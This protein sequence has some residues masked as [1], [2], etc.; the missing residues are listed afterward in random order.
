MYTVDEGCIVPKGWACK[1]VNIFKLAT[2]SLRLPFAMCVNTW[3]LASNLIVLLTGC[4]LHCTENDE[5]CSL[6]HYFWNR[7]CKA[8]P[9]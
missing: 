3:Y 6:G 4:H 5:D 2:M 1:V 8:M 7:V 9:T